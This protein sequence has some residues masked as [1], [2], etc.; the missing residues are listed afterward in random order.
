MTTLEMGIF[1]IIGLIMLIVGIITKKKW[2][3]IISLIPLVISIF[4]VLILI[5]SFI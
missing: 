4:Q 2:L 3:I 1:L 5:A